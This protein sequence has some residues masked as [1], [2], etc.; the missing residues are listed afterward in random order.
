MVFLKTCK[1]VIAEI[2]NDKQRGEGWI[3][4]KGGER[5]GGEKDERGEG[6]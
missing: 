1:Y 5:G 6:R 2:R 4:E 3:G